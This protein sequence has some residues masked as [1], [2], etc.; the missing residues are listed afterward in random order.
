[1]FKQVLISV[2]SLQLFKGVWLQWS[3][4]LPWARVVPVGPFMQWCNYA[5]VHQYRLV[6]ILYTMYNMMHFTGAACLEQMVA[7]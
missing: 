1:M 3:T 6:C 2:Y 4:A 7:G 5:A